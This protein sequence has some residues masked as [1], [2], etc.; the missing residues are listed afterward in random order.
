VVTMQEVA[1]RAGVT[2]QTVSN[3]VTGRGRVGTKTAERVRAVIDELGYVPNLVARGLA[4][5][6]TM[7]VALLVPTIEKPFYAEIAEAV[8]NVLD[9]HGYHLLLATTRFDAERGRRQLADLAGR[10]IDGML[11][12]GD[13]FLDEHL[14]LLEEARFPVALC[15]WENEFPDTLPVVTVDWNHAGYL[16]GKHLRELGHS[17][18]A[19]VADL[20]GHLPRIEGLRR[21]FARDGLTVPDEAVF[22]AAASTFGGAF[23]A[24]AAALAGPLRPTAFFA[25]HDVLA[26]G[27]MEAVKDAG[28]RIPH[29]VAVIGL[30]D[31]DLAAHTRPSL[32]TIDIP[33]REMAQAAT[34]LVLR[35]IREQKKPSNSIQQLRPRLIVRSSSGPAHDR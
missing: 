8:E 11:I 13:G 19:I 10:S 28:L 21:A 27:V 33:K 6:A 25:T 3:V 18:I 24:A 23:D 16:A 29:D 32:S 1:D 31:V 15:A 14:S 17:R 4:T 12:A 26:V 35:A 20:P 5:G 2:K 7:T 9:E 30:D 34:E 22:R